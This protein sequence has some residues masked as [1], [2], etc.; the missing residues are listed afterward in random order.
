MRV[1][2]SFLVRCWLPEKT[3]QC[4]PATLQIQHIQSGAAMRTA[5]LVDAESWIIET[6]RSENGEPAEIKYSKEH[7]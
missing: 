7:D 2:G 3:E 4:E 6:C 5:S 1:Y